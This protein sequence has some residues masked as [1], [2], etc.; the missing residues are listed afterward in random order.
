MCGREGDV[1]WLGGEGT[2][3]NGNEEREGESY[4]NANTDPAQIV[5]IVKREREETWLL[6]TVCTRLALCH[7]VVFS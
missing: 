3:L 6:D 7:F 4:L 1:R 2:I 5:L